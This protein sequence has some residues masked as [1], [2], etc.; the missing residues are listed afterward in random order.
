MI[1]TSEFILQIIE[2]IE[3]EHKLECNNEC[4]GRYTWPERWKVL[5]QRVKNLEITLD[6]E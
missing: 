4:D 2:Q 5:K 3:K 6:K 1:L